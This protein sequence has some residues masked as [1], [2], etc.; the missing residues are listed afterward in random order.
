[1]ANERPAFEVRQIG[2]LRV[3]L[4]LFPALAPG[5]K[6]APQVVA[7]AVTDKALALRERADLVIGIS[8]WGA[9]AEENFLMSRGHT[10]DI[11]FGAGPG[12]GFLA[13]PM[14]QDTVLWIRAYAQ[15]KT[16][17]QVVIKSLP[18]R[19]PDWKWTRDQNV[20]VLLQSLTENITNDPDMDALLAGFHLENPAN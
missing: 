16:L 8:P 7:Q 3:G 2:P 4:L 19:A 15:G 17:H 6:N 12:P 10:V 14:A 11:L 5:L 20:A 18:R 1:M 13:R 9:A